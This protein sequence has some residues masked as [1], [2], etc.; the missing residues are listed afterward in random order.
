MSSI[1][2]NN[3]VGLN[4]NQYTNDVNL[5]PK[6]AGIGSGAIG[7]S[8]EAPPTVPQ[9]TIANALQSLTAFMSGGA[10][11]DVDVL[12]VQVAVAM[13]DAEAGNQKAKINTDQETK[14]LQLK[15]KEEK[16]VEAQKKM[17]EAEAKRKSA[18][19]WDKIKLAFEWIGAALA[20]ALA[21][22]MIAT[23]VGAVVGA[24]LLVAAV[25]AI[26]M[27]VDSTVQQATGMGIAGNIAFLDAKANGKTDE[28]AKAAASKA[29]MGFR[30]AIAV[31]GIVATIVAGGAGAAGAF[32]S[33]ID[34]GKTAAQVGNSVKDI[35]L[36]AKSAFF[37]AL[38]AS[39]QT[40]SQTATMAREGLEIASVVNSL[41]TIA[42]TT[43]GSVTRAEATQASGEAKKLEARA[44]E[45][46]AVI[47]MLD[48]LIDQALSR[49]M[50]ASDRFNTILD[51][52]VEA[53]NDRGDTMSK[54]RFAG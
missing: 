40:L 38:R 22:V 12:L 4:T 31:I 50:A 53:M 9:E 25:A 6:K 41:G 45:D 3:P 10:Q 26:V 42:T 14:K 7:Q 49:L 21:V 5:D 23:G 32:K 34:A 35:V 11:V 24:A 16:L 8:G 1:Q 20:A 48:D 18:S 2:S 19:I 30:I 15:E 51:D 27:A 47:Q 13:R 39:A 33:A 36:A 29:D 54:A 17:D 43:G 44:K 52:I 37:E 46:E 28:E